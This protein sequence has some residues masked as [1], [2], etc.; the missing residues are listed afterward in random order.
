MEEEEYAFDIYM[1]S[2]LLKGYLCTIASSQMEIYEDIFENLSKL[3]G[4][5][6]VIDYDHIDHI[7]R[8]SFHNM[9][10]VIKPA[11]SVWA[12]DDNERYYMFDEKDFETWD[13]GYV[14]VSIVKKIKR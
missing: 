3:N 8:E 13:C 1:G 12:F 10:I 11:I 6:S 7:E 5:V 9:Q 2:Y 14:G 4:S